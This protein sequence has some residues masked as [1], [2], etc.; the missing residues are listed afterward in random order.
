MAVNVVR[1][2]QCSEVASKL[3]PTVNTDLPGYAEGG[4]QVAKASSSGRSGLVMQH[5][6]QNVLAVT[7]NKHQHVKGDSTNRDNYQVSTPNK[8][9]PIRQRQQLPCPPVRARGLLE[10]AGQAA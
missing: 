7:A 1:F 6:Q 8:P 4:Q 2:T 5:T 3:A 10:L 9:R